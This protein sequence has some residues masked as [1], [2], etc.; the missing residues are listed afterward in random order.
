MFGIKRERGE[1]EPSVVTGVDDNKKYKYYS[2][3]DYELAESYFRIETNEYKQTAIHIEGPVNKKKL[4]SDVGKY[5]RENKEKLEKQGIDYKKAI[6]ETQK[7]INENWS[8]IS[9]KTMTFKP[10]LIKFTN[11]FG[12]IKVD[13]S[14]LKILYLFLKESK[15]NIKFNEE[16]IIKILKTKSDDIKNICFYYSLENNLFDEI[17]D[18]I[19][20]HICVKTT[21][22]KIVGYVKLFSLT[23]YIC[24]LDDNYCGESF[25]CKYGFNLLSQKEFNPICHYLSNL[26]NL[27]EKFDYKNNYETTSKNLNKDYSRIMDLYYKLN[28]HAKFSEIQHLTQQKFIDI[29]GK[30]I[31]NAPMVKT[32]IDDLGKLNYHFS[33][34]V[35]DKQKDEIIS[36]IVNS[37]LSIIMIEMFKRKSN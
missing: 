37:A 24:I 5:F 11:A 6:K 29:F 10:N 4:L 9:T 31:I 35:T 33:E 18:E 22:N 28:P 32:I 3:G 20:H 26:D 27:K 36:K 12:G 15:P 8:E 14:I 21:D 30:D 1:S 17:E 16:N 7:Y 34:S 25:E 13:F 2:N 23:P 19:S